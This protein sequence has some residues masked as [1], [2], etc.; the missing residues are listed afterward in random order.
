MHIT[1]VGSKTPCLLCGALVLS[2]C[3]NVANIQDLMQTLSQK[4]Q[5]NIGKQ[6]FQAI[7]NDFTFCNPTEILLK[8]PVVDLPD[9]MSK[10]SRW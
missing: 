1:G 2:I 9:S 3:S 5:Q 10:L 6:G 8:T 7:G 4:N